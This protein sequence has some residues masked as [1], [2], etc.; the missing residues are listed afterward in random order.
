MFRITLLIAI[1][2]L[3]L[4]TFSQAQTPIADATRTAEIV[5]Q[6]PGCTAEMKE[7]TKSKLTEFIATHVLTPDLAKAQG[8]GGVVMVEFVVEKNGSIGEVRTL[9]DPGLGLGEEAVRVVSLMNEK[10]IKWKPAEEAGK[11]IPFR[12][13]TPVSFNLERL[14]EVVEKTTVQADVPADAIYDVVEVM[15][16]YAGCVVSPSDTIDCTFISM[17]NHIKSN[18]KYPEKAVEVSAQG[19]VVV[20]FVIDPQGMVTNPTVMKGLGYGCDEEAIRVIS[21]MPAWQP[22]LEKGKAVP[23]RMVVPIIFQAPKKS[24]E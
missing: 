12:Y 6:W 8:A 15:P 2:F 20:Q 18:L 11:R 3:G 24:E 7:C 17:L 10:K 5:P 22:G 13:M 19:P 16:R 4:Q 21:L 14:E 1:C 9:H 23:V